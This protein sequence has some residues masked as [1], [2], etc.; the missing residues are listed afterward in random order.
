VS[1]AVKL[2]QPTARVIGVESSAA[3]AMYE[4]IRAGHLVT[5]D[6][7]T[8]RADG[9]RVRRVG[10][11]TFRIVR[12]FVDEVVLVDEE[13]ISESILWALGRLKLLT[14]GAAAAT[15]AALMKG[16]AKV[17]AGSRIVCVLSGG[18]L[19]TGQFANVKVN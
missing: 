18:T 10:E 19:D 9:L 14:E 17:P 13:D 15:L 4:S 7:A 16:L 5:L 3:P 12:D 8:T 11:N 6:N 1:Q 2:R